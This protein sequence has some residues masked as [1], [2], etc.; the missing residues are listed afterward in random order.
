M[1]DLAVSVCAKHPQQLVRVF[2]MP[3]A[4]TVTQ[5][6]CIAHPSSQAFHPMHDGT[7]AAP[8]GH[9]LWRVCTV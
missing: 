5:L 2:F 8:S 3:I 4:A 1:S 7:R 6:L 9:I